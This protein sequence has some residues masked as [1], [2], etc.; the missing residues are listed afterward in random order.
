MTNTRVRCQTNILYAVEIGR[1]EEGGRPGLRSA[2]LR[3]GTNSATA[4]PTT[5]GSVPRLFRAEP[6]LGTTGPA[7]PS[8]AKYSSG[9]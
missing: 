7:N 4:A 3:L 5:S 9:V 8:R 2:E 1:W 6:E